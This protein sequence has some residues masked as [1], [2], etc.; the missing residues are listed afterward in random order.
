[1]VVV[2]LVMNGVGDCD[3]GGANA[4]DV[5][6]VAVILFMLLLLPLFPIRL[7]DSK[8]SLLLWNTFPLIRSRDP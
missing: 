8:V 6:T 2:E 1:M 4:V 3:G 5:D 7:L